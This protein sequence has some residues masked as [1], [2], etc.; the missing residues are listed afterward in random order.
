MAEAKTAP[1]STA[2]TAATAAV[3]KPQSPPKP[4]KPVQESAFAEHFGNVLLWLGVLFV[5]AAVPWSR[6]LGE[7]E[8]GF[9]LHA[10]H[11]LVFAGELK[12]F[13]HSLF[14]KTAVTESF[15]GP[16]LVSAIV[17]PFMAVLDPKLCATALS[18][19]RRLPFLVPYV[20]VVD[21]AEFLAVKSHILALFLARMAIGALT[22]ASWSFLRHR[23]VKRT[24][25][26]SVG[27]WFSLLLVASLMP[28]LS[29]SALQTSAISSLISILASH[30]PIHS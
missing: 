29:A 8:G 2:S 13:R 20:Q 5:A 17:R 24:G 27:V 23:L 4:G 19:L 30:I 7:G 25:H 14:G 3:S 18:H 1:S 12:E 15:L 16:M 11:D 9:F 6:S 22:V 26:Q 28:L 10:L 21:E